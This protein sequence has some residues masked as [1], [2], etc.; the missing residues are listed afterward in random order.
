MSPAWVAAA[1]AVSAGGL[2]ATQA[3]LLAWLKALLL[4]T[5]AEVAFSLRE[6]L[7]L[8]E[9][10]SFLALARFDGRGALPADVLFKG[11]PALGH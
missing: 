3:R 6:L 7:P 4:D 10:A 11:P 1:R 5:R 9:F 2:F 8:G